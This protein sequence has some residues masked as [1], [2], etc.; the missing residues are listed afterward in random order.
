M[1]WI[2]INID[3]ANAKINQFTII[4]NLLSFICISVYSFFYIQI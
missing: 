1:N 2:K 4:Y 3:F